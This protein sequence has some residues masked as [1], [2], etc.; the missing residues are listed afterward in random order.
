[1]TPTVPE[2]VTCPEG[3]HEACEVG[4]MEVRLDGKLGRNMTVYRCKTE[5]ITEHYH[6]PGPQVPIEF[7]VLDS[8]EKV[9]VQPGA[10]QYA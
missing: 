2:T 7:V 5:C 8:E 3:N 10:D 4:P 6:N 1:M 9:L